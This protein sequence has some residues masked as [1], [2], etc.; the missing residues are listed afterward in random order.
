VRPWLCRSSKRRSPS[1]FERGGRLADPGSASLDTA[2][3]QDAP[4]RP[5]HAPDL[6]EVLTAEG[7]E[8]QAKA[9]SRPCHV[10][11][12]Q[13]LAASEAARR[14]RPAAP[15]ASARRPG[16]DTHPL[17]S[18]QESGAKYTL[19]RTNSKRRSTTNR[20]TNKASSRSTLPKRATLPSHP[21][22][23][24][25][26]T[27][28]LRLIEDRLVEPESRRRENDSRLKTV[29]IRPQTAARCPQSG[30]VRPLRD[31]SKRK[32]VRGPSHII[33]S[34]IAIP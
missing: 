15:A 11:L 31:P 6:R 23:S 34:A 27:P 12:A 13:A 32:P 5:P 8:A 33:C 14:A 25:F 10:A 29:G 21:S 19:C 30:R 22:K 18:P 7:T 24:E 1:C 2:I 17:G 4:R 9:H 20:H 26:P 3:A 16:W 28:F